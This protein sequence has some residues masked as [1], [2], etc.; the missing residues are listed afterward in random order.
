MMVNLSRWTTNYIRRNQGVIVTINK[1]KA[2][3]RMIDPN[4]FVLWSSNAT[5]KSRFQRPPKDLWPI[6][7]NNNIETLSII[8]GN[9]MAIISI[10]SVI[11]IS[12]IIIIISMV[13]SNKTIIT[14]IN[15]IIETITN[16][17]DIMIKI[18]DQETISTISNTIKGIKISVDS[19]KFIGNRWLR[20]KKI[21]TFNTGIRSSSGYWLKRTIIRTFTE[22]LSKAATIRTKSISPLS[23]HSLIYTHSSKLMEANT[24]NKMILSNKAKRIFPSLMKNN[25]QIQKILTKVHLLIYNHHLNNNLN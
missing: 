25:P 20:N 19:K 21:N 1:T 17:I 7:S 8:K 22:Q 11:S 3:L 15:K 2:C 6:T 18:T 14:E 13:N 23:K 5:S 9:N 24:I 10:I 12:S 16:H 4:A